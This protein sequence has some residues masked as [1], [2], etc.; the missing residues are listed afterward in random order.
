MAERKTPYLEYGTLM[1]QR[2]GGRVQKIAI[3]AH[4]SC[5]NR[6]G[7]LGYGGCTF[8]LGEAF[9]PS[10]CREH[11]SVTAQI[12]AGIAFH[13]QRRRSA[14]HYIAYFQA[15]TNTHAPIEH[16]KN[17][18]AEALN[19][20]SI[21][22]IIIGT[23]PDCISSEIVELLSNLANNHYVAIEFGIEST[24]D[25]TLSHVN[26]HHDFACA[27]ESIA[28][29]KSRGLDIGVHLILGLPNE[30]REEIMV[31]VERINSLP[32]DF[33][34]FHQLQ[35]YRNTPLAEEWTNHPE[36]FLFGSNTT[37]EEYIDLIIDILRHLRPD[38]AIERFASQAPPHLLLHSPLKG[39]RPDM[40]REAIIRNMYAGNFT[41]GDSLGLK[42]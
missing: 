36:R 34:K 28:L 13:T 16:L 40:L 41:Q 21:E 18:Y 8:C 37:S 23:R 1:R 42:A 26:R 31:S 14:D 5:P 3:D 25:S 9:S 17:L 12:D 2:F 22:G 27:K 6:D 20:P 24:H 39:M 30:G 29:C 38:I 11:K 35:I 15:G 7:T 19:H 10:Y 4:L 32:I 33:V